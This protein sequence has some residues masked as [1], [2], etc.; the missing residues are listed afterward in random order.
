M[1]FIL[2]F[3]HFLIYAFNKK[4]PYKRAIPPKTEKEF[5]W[6]PGDM[7]GA[8][9]PLSVILLSIAFGYNKVPLRIAVPKNIWVKSSYA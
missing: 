7:F 1:T 3:S 9:S 8:A 5:V 6:A 2:S 4:N